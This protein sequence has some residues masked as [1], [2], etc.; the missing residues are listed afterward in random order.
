MQK[1]L[2][3]ILYKKDNKTEIQDV[4]KKKQKNHEKK[5]R[6]LYEIDE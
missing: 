1:K 4:S 5:R 2:N 3:K 6:I